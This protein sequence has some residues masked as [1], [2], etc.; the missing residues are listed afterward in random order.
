MYRLTPQRVD[1]LSVRGSDNSEDCVLFTKVW[2]EVLCR[3][4]SVSSATGAGGSK[5]AERELNRTGTDTSIMQLTADDTTNAN[6]INSKGTAADCGAGLD[7]SPSILSV[8]NVRSTM[9]YI[10]TNKLPIKIIVS[11]TYTAGLLVVPICQIMES[12][13]QSE[14]TIP[15]V[16]MTGSYNP[17][18][19][20]N[21]GNDF[22]NLVGIFMYLFEFGTRQVQI[23][24]TVALN[25]LICNLSRCLLLYT[26][27]KPEA[28]SQNAELL[29]VITE[30]CGAYTLILLEKCIEKLLALH[31]MSSRR[32]IDANRNNLQY[33]NNNGRNSS[34]TKL[35]NVT[36]AAAEMESASA[37]T[38]ASVG[39]GLVLVSKQFT[40]KVYLYQCTVLLHSLLQLATQVGA[41][42]TSTRSLSTPP[43]VEG[44]GAQNSMLEMVVNPSRSILTYHADDIATFLEELHDAV[45]AGNE[46]GQNETTAPIHGAVNA[47][48][49]TD[50]FKLFTYANVNGISGDACISSNL[51]TNTHAIPV[52]YHI[53]RI[54]HFMMEICS[55]G[56]PVAAVNSTDALVKAPSASVSQDLQSC[57]EAYTEVTFHKLL[58]LVASGSVTSTAV[59]S[60]DNEGER[61]DIDASLEPMLPFGDD[62]DEI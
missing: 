47:Q 42:D 34:S 45:A 28:K 9:Q 3:L 51:Y 14:S 43:C 12:R 52:L 4:L 26:E 27:L 40:S 1:E 16:P 21:I 10:L 49:D 31:R 7:G 54:A 29:K 11:Y 59:P 50:Y 6:Y 15:S 2:N 30:G 60:V 32:G 33:S 22:V 58:W 8:S 23:L 24:A 48:D 39:Y 18:F 55:I 61:V 5:K 25:R 62:D 57:C 53:C 41:Y 19:T 38:D 35:G 37:G 36:N 17:S 56:A 44:H 46:S 13:F 20:V